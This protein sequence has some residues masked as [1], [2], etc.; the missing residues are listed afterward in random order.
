M[1]GVEDARVVAWRM[2]GSWHGGCWVVDGVEDVGVVAWWMAWRML[3]W[4][5]GGWCGEC[6]GSGVVDGIGD[7]T[8]FS[9]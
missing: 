1:D 3:G 9:R 8:E 6:W 4:L 2:L 5:C 7:S